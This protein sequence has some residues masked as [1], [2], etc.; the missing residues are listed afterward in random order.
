[1]R[2]PL[3]ACVGV[4]ALAVSPRAAFPCGA[5]VAVR[6]PDLALLEAL[7]Q[8]LAEADVEVVAPGTPCAALEVALTPEAGGIRLTPI[9]G[10]PVW[11]A[12]PAPAAAFLEARVLLEREHRT[13]EHL[14]QSGRSLAVR[15]ELDAPTSGGLGGGLALEL[16]QP[17][18]PRWALIARGRGAAGEQPRLVVPLTDVPTRWRELSGTAGLGARLPVTRWLSAQAALVGGVRWLQVVTRGGGCRPPEPCTLSDASPTLDGVQ[19]TGPYGELSLGLQLLTGD[20]WGFDVACTFALGEA[21]EDR[22]GAVISRPL[23]LR[24]GAGVRVALP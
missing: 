6:T 10:T 15:A 8:A 11:A 7:T 3:L 18:S 2:A 17:L 20:E 13:M 9:G 22:L 1:M 23:S 14:L 5:R 21:V 16:T 24:P 19:H 4:L 12:G